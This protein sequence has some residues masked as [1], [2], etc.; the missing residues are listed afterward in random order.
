MPNQS[1]K[2]GDVIQITDSN[3]K[4]YGVILIVSEV[5]SWGVQGYVT[6][7]LQGDAYYRIDFGKFELVG[8]AK[9]IAG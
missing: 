4:W 7:P 6:M 5:K 9:L 2:R 1:F 8:V 3:D